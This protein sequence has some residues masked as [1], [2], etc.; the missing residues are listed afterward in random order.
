MN[1][2]QREI[3]R[4]VGNDQEWR[5]FMLSEISSI[6]EKQNEFAVSIEALKNKMT[7]I[8]LIAGFVAGAMANWISKKIGG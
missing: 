8:G 1:D 3:D 6:K 2:N 7:F 5:R 4:I